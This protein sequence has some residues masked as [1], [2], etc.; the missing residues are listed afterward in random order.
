MKIVDTTELLILLIVRKTIAAAGRGGG[1][2]L[3]DNHGEIAW[4][5]AD[6]T[7]LAISDA[8]NKW[9]KYPLDWIE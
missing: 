7:L 8:V 5:V 4:Q 2:I 1:F 6:E 9:G 3:L